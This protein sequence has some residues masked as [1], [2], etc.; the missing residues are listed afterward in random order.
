MDEQK[1][2]IYAIEVI[3]FWSG[4]QG[5]VFDNVPEAIDHLKENDYVKVDPAATLAHLKMIVRYENGVVLDGLY[6]STKD[7]VWFLENKLT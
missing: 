4:E 7:A 3:P 2:E 1:L 6:P 5:E